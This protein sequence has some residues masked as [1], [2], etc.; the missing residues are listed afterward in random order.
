MVKL[1][2]P[3]KS[4][5]IRIKK[6][7][8]SFMFF[9]VSKILFFLT[10]PT[11]WLI[12]MLIWAVRTKNEMRR[13][14]LLGVTLGLAVVL[15]NPF[16]ANTVFHA[17]EVKPL[18]INTLHDTFDVGI[19]L[20]GFSEFDVYPIEDRLNLTVASNRLA[21]AVLLYKKGF[22]K[23]FLISG[24]DGRLAGKKISEATQVGRYLH[25][26][27]IPDSAVWLERESRNTFENAKYCKEFLN[28]KLPTARCLLITSAFH[29]RR[30]QGCFKKVG[31]AATPFPAHFIA[32]RIQLD[33][34]STIEPDDQCFMKWN[35]FIKEWIGWVAYWATGRI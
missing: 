27:G 17:W 29:M 30:A 8:I 22:I 14:K 10:L 35:M 2:N 15:T 3:P 18:S 12:L 34:N 4:A 23:H 1:K 33:A 32:E 20:G 24:G 7:E 16:I 11:V 19:V 6:S 26:I 9:A 31:F 25:D 21:D 13:K 28:T 5:K